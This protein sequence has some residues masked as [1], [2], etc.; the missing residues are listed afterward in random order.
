M[1][2][3]STIRK[4]LVVGAGTM[5]HGIAQSFAQ[6]GFNVALYSRTAETLERA[7]SLIDYSLQAFVKEKMVAKKD[8]PTILKRIDFTQSLDKAA[9]DSDIAFETVIENREAKIDIFARLDRLCPPKTLLASNTTA[10]NVF[11]FVKTSRP[12]EVLISHWYAPPQIIPL[13]DVVKGPDTSEES[14]YLMA[15]LLKKIG[16]A[17]LVLKKF[18]PGY[19]LS[20]L[21]I[22]MLGEIFYLLDSDIVT[23]EQLD[24]AAKTGLALRMMVVGLVQRMDFGGLDLTVRN[25]ENPYMRKQLTPRDYKPEK[26]Y[27]LVREGHFGVKT[28]KGFYDYSGRTEAEVCYE[29]D[30]K[31]IRMLRA[32]RELESTK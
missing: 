2:D 18:I 31:L 27:K 15:A 8:I 5:G 12:D 26:I 1:P 24:T 11:D 14:V 28:G 10:L 9:A 22:A 29:R 13:V 25:F 3:V 20:R 21:Q 32:Y 30:I 23:P 19:L 17:P 16:K 4:I 7:R 6:E